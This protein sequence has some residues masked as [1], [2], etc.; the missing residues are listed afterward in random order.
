MVA[1]RTYLTGGARQ[2]PPR[3]G[4]RGPVRAAA[5]PGLRRDV[6]VDRQ[7]DARLAAAPRDRRAASAPTSSSGRSTTASCRDSR[8]TGRHSSTTNPL[9]RRTARLAAADA[10]HGGARPMDAVRLLPAEPD[11]PPELL[12]A[13]PRDDRRRRAPGPPVRHGRDR[14]GGR[15][16]VRS[17]CGWRRTIRG[18]ATCAVTV[19][20][21][22]DRPW[23]LSLRV[24]AWSRADDAGRRRERGRPPADRRAD[25]RRDPRLAVRGRGRPR[26]STSGSGSS[27]PT[28]GSTPSAAAS[29]SSAVRSSTASRSADLPAGDRARGPRA[30]SGGPPGAGRPPRPGR[31]HRRADA[32]RRSPD[33]PTTGL[34]V[35]RRRPGRAAGRRRGR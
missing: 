15:P 29:R 3:R 25:D 33:G 28:V 4:V 7:R 10:G 35:R 26:A 30:R 6:R 22:P 34:A 32:A 11:A 9:Q 20:E 1:T 27:S 12:A 17:G 14:R 2:P 19:L 16:A 13:V 23:T 24:P 18:P 21:T 31:R 5:G 8:S